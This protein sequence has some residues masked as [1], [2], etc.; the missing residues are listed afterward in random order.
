MNNQGSGTKEIENQ[1]R[2]QKFTCNII[3][4]VIIFKKAAWMSGCLQTCNVVIAKFI[5]WLVHGQVCK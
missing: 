2:L 3:E 4:H 1:P 5:F